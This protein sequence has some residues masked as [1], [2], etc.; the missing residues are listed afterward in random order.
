MIVEGLS[1][2]ATLRKTQADPCAEGLAEE[3]VAAVSLEVPVRRSSQWL[4]SVTA[5]R[6]SP[7][8]D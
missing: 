5:R 1:K 2:A 7:S 3:P 4:L 8:S 6:R